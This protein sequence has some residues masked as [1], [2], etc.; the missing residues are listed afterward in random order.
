MN[1]GL[2]IGSLLVP[3]LIAAS[4]ARAALIGAGALLVVLIVATGRQLL[5]VDE[6][7]DVPVVEIALL[8]S[9][10]LFAALP[11]PA[12]ETLGRALEPV[13]ADAGTVLMRQGEDGDRYYAI[14]EGQLEV[15]HDGSHVATLGRGEGVGEIALLEDVPRTATVWVITPARLYALTKEP[16]VLALTGHAPADRAARRIVKT[17]R[18]HLVGLDPG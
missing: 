6:A 8:R 2:A 1:V 17:R 10:P 5:Q 4:G 14:A 12:F 3:I 7:A 16:F 18:D 15:L 13:S 9:I 11:A